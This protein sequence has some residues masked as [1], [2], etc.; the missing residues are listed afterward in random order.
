MQ[1]G[2]P[3]FQADSSASGASGRVTLHFQAA[4]PGQT[5]LQLIYHRPFEKDKPPT[6]SYAVTVQV[7]Q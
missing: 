2:E 3:D 4:G 5:K 6:N 7:G 1:L